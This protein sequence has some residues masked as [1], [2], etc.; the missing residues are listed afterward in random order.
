MCYIVPLHETERR[1]WIS[2]VQN[3][4]H[5]RRIP[6]RRGVLDIYRPQRS[7]EGYIF[8]PVC[9][10]V[11]GGVRGVVVLS[12]HALQV[13]SEHALQQ[14]SGGRGWHPSMPC[15]FPGPQPR[16]SWGDLPGGRG[17]PAPGVWIPPL[18]RTVCILLECI[19][20]SSFLCSHY[21]QLFE[22]RCE[23]DVNV[24]LNRLF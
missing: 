11:H 8:T 22:N 6:G 12:Q 15:R 3:G 20:V 24:S 21:Q 9:H 1:S 17:V 14:V 4:T 23:W 10:S 19:L 18:L 7:C 16:G 2:Q 5:H 13:V